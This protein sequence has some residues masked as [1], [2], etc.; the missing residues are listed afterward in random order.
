MNHSTVPQ[1][2]SPFDV[3]RREKKCQPDRTTLKRRGNALEL[4]RPYAIKC[5][6]FFF[7]FLSYSN[8]QGFHIF[9]R[10]LLNISSTYVCSAFERLNYLIYRHFWYEG[11]KFV[12]HKRR[13][14]FFDSIDNAHKQPKQYI[15]LVYQKFING[16]LLSV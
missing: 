2:F 5:S 14:L 3:K 15:N 16:V 6:K 4:E 12:Q 10:I 7:V 1:I 8:K 13:D 11:S 9:G